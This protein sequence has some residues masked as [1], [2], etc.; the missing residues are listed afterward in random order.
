M[1]VSQLREICAENRASSFVSERRH[2]LLCHQRFLLE[3][4]LLFLLGHFYININMYYVTQKKILQLL[5]QMTFLK[6]NHMFNTD[7]DVCQFE[8]SIA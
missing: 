6:K 2:P 4:K 3:Q 1:F 7:N 8:N 5:K